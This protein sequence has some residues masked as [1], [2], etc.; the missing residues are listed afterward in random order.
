MIKV[1]GFAGP[2]QL[3]EDRGSNTR[4]WKERQLAGVTLEGIGPCRDEDPVCRVGGVVMRVP[5][6]SVDTAV[7][8]GPFL[9]ASI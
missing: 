4:V 7:P 1:V 6:W 8:G 3:F 9:M 5:V 2:V